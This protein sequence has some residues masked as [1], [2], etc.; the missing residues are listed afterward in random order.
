[1]E[2]R[3]VY[4]EIG[5]KEYPLRFSIGASKA[6]AEKFGSFEE[7]TEKIK[8]DGNAEAIEAIV[9]IMALLVEQ[10]CAYKNLFES[11]VPK[12][13]NAPV[14]DGKYIPI[15]KEYLEIGMD[16]SDMAE[17]KTKIFEALSGGKK[18]DIKSKVK[19]DGSPKNAE[20]T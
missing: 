17:I 1:M 9:W 13:D 7:M 20:A 18:R 8:S 5:G 6:I 15:T 10:G 12:P 2:K 4:I 19:D 3:T 11:D 16:L 14:K